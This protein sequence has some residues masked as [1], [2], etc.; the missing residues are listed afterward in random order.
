MIPEEIFKVCSLINEF[1]V[2]LINYFT[3]YKENLYILLRIVSPR[4]TNFKE[5]IGM[6]AFLISIFIVRA[7]IFLAHYLFNTILQSL[8][9]FEIPK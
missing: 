9:N 4:M 2:Q 1:S 7:N 5:L 3:F 6:V 8:L